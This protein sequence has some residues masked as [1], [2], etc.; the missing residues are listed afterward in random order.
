MLTA[1]TFNQGGALGNDLNDGLLSEG[2][3][4]RISNGTDDAVC[5]RFTHALKVY[6]ADYDPDSDVLYN[7]NSDPQIVLV[8]CSDYPAGG[9]DPLARV[10]YYAEL[11]KAS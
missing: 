9:G 5:Y 3:I 6:V 4:F 11:V 1:H 10:L 8:V 7:D 2:D